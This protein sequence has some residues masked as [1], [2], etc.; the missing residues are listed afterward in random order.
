MTAISQD[1]EMVAGESRTLQFMVLQ[2]GSD[3]DLTS[4]T[5]VWRLAE[6]PNGSAVLTKTESSGIT[7]TDAAAGEC[8]VAISAG[9]I[10]SPGLYFH[11]LEVT[12]SGQTYIA[13]RGRV[14]VRGAPVAS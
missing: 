9:D 1:F 6:S 7:V 13:A 2:A 8:E 11:V 4:A 5:L 12:V 14:V 10:A 3:Y